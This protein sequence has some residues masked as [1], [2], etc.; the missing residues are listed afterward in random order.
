VSCL[1]AIL[2]KLTIRTPIPCNALGQG[3]LAIHNEQQAL[4]LKPDFQLAWALSKVHP[5]TPH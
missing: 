4:R 2:S 3:D 5:A 1:K